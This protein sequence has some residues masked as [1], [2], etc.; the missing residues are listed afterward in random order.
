MEHL[1]RVPAAERVEVRRLGVVIPALDLDLGIGAM[2]DLLVRVV[3]GRLVAGE[4][5]RAETDGHPLRE[6]VVAVGA[7]QEVTPAAADDAEPVGNEHEHVLQRASARP[8]ELVGVGVDHPVR[9]VV[10]RG[11]ARHVRNPLLLAH[12]VA[13]LVEEARGSPP[14]RSAR[15][16]PSSRPTSRCRS[17]S[18][19]RHPR[20]EWNAI[21]AS[22]MSASS[23]TSSVITSFIRISA[24]ARADLPLRGAG[25]PERRASSTRQ[26]PAQRVRSRGSR[27]AQRP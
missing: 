9:A 2:R 16:S 25:T 19:S 13:S 10:G 14:A 27:G 17:R 3:D 11:Q 22:T 15:G 20:A 8:P 18:R 6:G 12:V 21:C 4:R 1:D 26:L 7:R 5:R 24:A 23:R